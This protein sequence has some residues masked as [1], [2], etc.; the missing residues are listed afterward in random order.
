MTTFNLKI[1]TNNAAFCP[2]DDQDDAGEALRME[3]ARILREIAEALENG[4]DD[5]PAMDANGNRVGSCWMEG[6]YYVR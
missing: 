5:P 1:K 3:L 4:D 2:V 6:D